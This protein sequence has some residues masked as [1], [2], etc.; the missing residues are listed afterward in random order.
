MTVFQIVS[1]KVWGGGERYVLDLCRRLLADGRDVRVLVRPCAAPVIAAF[2]GEGVQAAPLPMRGFGRLWGVRRL[3]RE[4][5]QTR[6]EVVAHV[7]NFVDARFVAA[8]RRCLP[9]PERGRVRIVCTRHL[10]RPGR[11][12]AVYGEIDALIFVSE[13]ARR[14]FLAGKAQIDEAKI[15]VVPNS[16]I[17]LEP[18][19]RPAHD[20][21]MRLL[22][23]GRLADEKGVGT[24]LRASAL[25]KGEWRLRICGTGADKSVAEY[26]RLAAELGLAERVEWPGHVSDVYAE[27]RGADILVAPSEVPEAF[28]LSALEAMSQG[29]AVVASDIGALPELVAEG[30]CGL[31]VPVSDPEAL[32]AALGRLVA[33]PALCRAMGERGRRAYLEAHTYDA[34]YR[35]IT[36]IYNGE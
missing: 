2:A 23:A 32:A 34:F 24:L 21:A 9:A 22:F 16:I 8:A 20:G 10:A 30:E 15:R 36:A 28:G 17:A 3:A 6:G 29:V 26:K 14:V 35:R 27:L 4:L 11:R 33:D 7:H 18:A 12:S 31:L 1:N 25:L 5:A 13:A 19:L